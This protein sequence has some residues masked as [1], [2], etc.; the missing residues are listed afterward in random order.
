MFIL[1]QVKKRP[2][3]V[4]NTRKTEFDTD[5]V[6]FK[7]DIEDLRL[8]LQEFLDKKFEDIPSA[9]RSLELL[10]K[11]EKIKGL[12]LALAEKY[13]KCLSVFEVELE[14]IRKLFNRDNAEPPIP[15]NSP[16]I[17]V[18]LILSKRFLSLMVCS[19]GEFCGAVNSLNARN[20]PWMFSLRV[21]RICWLGLMVFGPFASSTR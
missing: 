3:D 8:R 15:R 5:F 2:Y 19:R 9:A 10:E 18:S 21:P 6:Q 4:L 12:G 1:L 17:T 14:D 13:E 20:R 7:R 16:P 11:F